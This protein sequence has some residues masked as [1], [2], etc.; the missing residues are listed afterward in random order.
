MNILLIVLLF[1]TTPV[2]A[3]DFIINGNDV[4]KIEQTTKADE[5]IA[6]EGGRVLLTAQIKNYEDNASDYQAK[7][8]A[9]KA[10]L[11]EVERRIAVL[12]E[13]EIAEPET[14]VIDESIYE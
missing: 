1:L 6:L 11:A 14:P 9:L 4:Y 2:M 7:A 5:M 3:E 8:N 10:D 13:P 12:N